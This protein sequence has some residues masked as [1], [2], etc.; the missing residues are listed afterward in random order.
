MLLKETGNS[1]NGN[2]P[3]IMSQE[4]NARESIDRFLKGAGGH[5]CD[6]SQ[7]NINAARGVAIREFPLP[8]FGFAD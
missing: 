6:A 5:V 7:A 3:K 2:D 8:G 1:T 4:S